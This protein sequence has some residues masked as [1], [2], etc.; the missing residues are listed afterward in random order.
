[1]KRSLLT[2]GSIQLT[3]V[4]VV[5]AFLELDTLN[6]FV[7]LFAFGLVITSLCGAAGFTVFKLTERR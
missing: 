4:A 1:M 7:G 5:G 6:E 2:L 3:F